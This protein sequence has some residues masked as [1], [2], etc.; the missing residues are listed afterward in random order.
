M[1]GASLSILL[2]V[3]AQVAAPPPPPPC[4]P[5]CAEGQYCA[6]DGRCYVP[7]P[8]PPPAAA[9]GAYAPQN[10]PPQGGYTPPPNQPGGYA[11]APQQPPPGYYAPPQNQPP[12]GY[13]APPQGQPA[14]GYYPPPNQPQ[15]GYPPPGGYQ[16][17]A[18]YGGQPAAVYQPQPAPVRRGPTYKEGPRFG[19]FLGGI[20]IPG[21]DVTAAAGGALLTFGSQPYGFETRIYGAFYRVEEEDTRTTGSV[22]VAH[23]TRWWGAYGL[24]FGSG[25]GYADFTAR[26]S[27]G[28]NDS[29]TQL[30]AYVAPVMLRF[31]RQPTFE[32][33]LNSGASLFFTHDVGPYGYVYGGILF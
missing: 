33:G 3:F 10:Q 8:P 22:F 1:M 32:L 19:L 29:S 9:P 11:P 5:P 13:Y 25:V 26:T 6:S 14:P 28:W 23:G 31:G 21:T 12:P 15:A 20:A 24:G 17:P 30:I 16:Q 27:Y 2:T 18:P 4:N 7:A